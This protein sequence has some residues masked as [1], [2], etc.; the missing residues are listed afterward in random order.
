V[1]PV[2]RAVEV[3][4]SGGLVAFPTETV[5]GLGADADNPA[6]VRRIFAAKGRPPGRALTVHLGPKAKPE[7]WG[8]WPEHARRLASAFWPGPLTVIV[9]RTARVPDLVTGGRDTVGLR[10]PSHPLAIS[11][12]DA[13]GGGVAAPSANRSGRVSPTCADDVRAELGSAVDLVL[14]GGACPVGVESTVLTLA[15]DPPQVLRLGAVTPD[16]LEE[17]LGGPVRIPDGGI[18]PRYQPRT[19]LRVLPG[20]QLAA[21][22]ALEPGPVAVIA[23]GRPPGA[24]VHWVQAPADAETYARELYRML[25]ALDEGGYAAI[26]V[27]EVPEGGLWEAVAARLRAAESAPGE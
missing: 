26:L 21:A 25:R 5:Y 3:L 7:E 12:L 22:V 4:R 27:A 15:E 16:L 1:D 19:P 11:M 17:V 9:P 23:P 6:A 13:F 24:R 20:D 10:V 2:E 14:D 8:D 18:A